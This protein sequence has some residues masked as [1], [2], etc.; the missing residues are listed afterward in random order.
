MT[1]E[2][3]PEEVENLRIV[4]VSGQQDERTNVE[5]I[6]DSDVLPFIQES[7]RH[8]VNLLSGVVNVPSPKGPMGNVVHAQVQVCPTS[9][10]ALGA[11]HPFKKPNSRVTKLG[12]A[13]TNS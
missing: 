9:M 11:R 8:D 1:V 10:G 7:P 12:V 5:V 13:Q 2:P 4:K 3:Q 6:T